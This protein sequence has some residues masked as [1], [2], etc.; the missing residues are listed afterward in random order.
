M[1]AMLALPALQAWSA[2]GIA[3]PH[4]LPKYEALK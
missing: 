1:D 4:R 3:E 2:A